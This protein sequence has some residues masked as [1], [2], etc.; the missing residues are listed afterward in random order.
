MVH[1][2]NGSLFFQFCPLILLPLQNTELEGKEDSSNARTV[3]ARDR[4][5]IQDLPSESAFLFLYSCRP[6]LKLR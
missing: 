4:S 6:G 2:P 5:E 1:F 3:G